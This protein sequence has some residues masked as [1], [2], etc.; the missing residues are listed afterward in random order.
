MNTRNATKP[1]VSGR[2]QCIGVSP[3]IFEG[4]DAQCVR[5]CVWV[6]GITAST[7]AKLIQT[8][9]KYERKKT[10]RVWPRAKAQ[11]HGMTA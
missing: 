10:K 7:S 5:V 9:P 1:D 11:F 2:S 3:S 8:R 4:L 6:C